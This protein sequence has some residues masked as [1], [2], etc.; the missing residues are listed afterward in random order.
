MERHVAG[1][2]KPAVRG[3]SCRRCDS[4]GVVCVAEVSHI[5]WRRSRHQLGTARAVTDRGTSCLFE[6][7]ASAAKR[8]G[9]ESKFKTKDEH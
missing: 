5:L 9:V 7:Q 3:S 1:V 4:R 6:V 2:Q 8:T